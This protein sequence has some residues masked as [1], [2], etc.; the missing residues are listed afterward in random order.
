MKFIKD[1]LK[2]K[3]APRPDPVIL[4]TVPTLVETA[5][6]EKPGFIGKWKD[7]LFGK[8]G[9]APKEEA[10]DNLFT[11]ESMK[12]KLSELVDSKNGSHKRNIVL[13][14]AGG[15]LAVAGMAADLMFLGGIGTTAVLGMMY[16][17]Y[18]NK[19][20]IEKISAE[21]SKIDTK[22]DEMKKTRQPVPDY[23]PA[24][25]AVKSSIEDFQASAQKV[26]PEVAEELSR[27]K[28]QVTALQGKI[29]PANDDKSAKPVVPA[30]G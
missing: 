14:V 16:S 17:D 28:N 12:Q 20:H 24:L 4:A 10:G 11:L 3:A 6:E 27:L 7:K 30:V 18:R 22:I 13:I 26:P 29:A 21:L 1:L 2:R 23:A 8:K 19:Q 25:S 15:G 5:V 9:D